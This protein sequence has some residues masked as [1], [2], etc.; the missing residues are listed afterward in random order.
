LKD[1]CRFGVQNGQP[2]V[3]KRLAIVDSYKNT[4]RLSRYDREGNRIIYLNKAIKMVG[5]VLQF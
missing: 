2:R 3:M 4:P 5:A 1:S